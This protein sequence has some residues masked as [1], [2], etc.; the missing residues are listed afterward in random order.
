M[1]TLQY[2]G[3]GRT[4]ATYSGALAD[5]DYDQGGATVA[6]EVDRAAETGTWS[7]ASSGLFDGSR[8]TSTV[9]GSAD[10]TAPR[11]SSRDWPWAMH[12]RCM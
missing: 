7:E 2:D 6:G 9:T 1:E 8:S 10:S 3:A 12:T 11:G 5:S 4:V